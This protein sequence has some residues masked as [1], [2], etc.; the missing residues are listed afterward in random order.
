MI[1]KTNKRETEIE[2]SINDLIDIID[3]NNTK[4]YNIIRMFEEQNKEILSLI[5]ELVK[6]EEKGEDK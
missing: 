4:I 5:N 6:Y 2:Q 3:K 1:W